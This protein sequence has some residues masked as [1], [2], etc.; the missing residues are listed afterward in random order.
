M[1]AVLALLVASLLVLPAPV[2]VAG[3]PRAA[4][5]LRVARQI[6]DPMAEPAAYDLYAACLRSGLPAQVGARAAATAAPAA[7]ARELCRSADLIALGGDPQAVWS[8]PDL[9]GSVR[10]LAALAR[11]S[12]R[13]GASM[14]AA[15]EDLAGE[16][17]AD[18]DE[19]AAARAERAGV[20]IAGPLGLCFLPAFVCIGIVPVVLGLVD[21]LVG[22][23]SMSDFAG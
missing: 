23:G 8:R 15:L 11:R 13:S 6:D 1:S 21:G 2:R 4:A 5:P 22:G 14:A 18:L 10:D 17:R 20:L 19:I 3:R 7:M 12:A 16:R 9:D